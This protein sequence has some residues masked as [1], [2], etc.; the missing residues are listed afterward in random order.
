M[1][2]SL[3]PSVP[4]ACVVVSLPRPLFVSYSTI[5]QSSDAQTIRLF[6]RKAAPRSSAAVRRLFFSFHSPAR[7][8][9]LRNSFDLAQ[10]CS[11][12]QYRPSSSPIPLHRPPPSRTWTLA[13]YSA[14]RVGESQLLSLALGSV[15]F[16]RY[17]SPARLP[18]TLNDTKICNTGIPSACGGARAF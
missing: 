7:N 6:S 15:A 14:W 8:A 11:S 5:S 9:D 12:K 10:T 3:N 2:L 13:F 16:C 17:E 18:N 1:V 4:V